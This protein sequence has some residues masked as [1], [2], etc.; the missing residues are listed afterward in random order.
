MIFQ[1]QTD[2]QLLG[3]QFDQRLFTRRTEL[4]SAIRLEIAVDAISARMNRTWGTVTD[5]AEQYNISRTFVYSLAEKLKKAGHFL[6]SEISSA[7]SHSSVRELAIQMMTS[8]RMEGKSSIGAISTI[9]GRF[10]LEFSS[11]GSISQILFHIGAL[12]P[13]TLSVEEGATQYLVFASDELFSKTT[14]ILVTVD[15][16]S[17]AI[18]RIELSDS[19]KAEDWANH[20]ECIQENGIEAIYV[21]S[22]DGKGIL[23]GHAEVMGDKIRQSDTYCL[24]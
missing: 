8:L 18:L 17:S 2:V 24:P 22:D 6:F 5:L 23:A 12:L 9:M 19:R 11:V 21:V 4:S 1:N 15:P 3:E 13:T 10:E 7:V 14:P 20:F 16:S